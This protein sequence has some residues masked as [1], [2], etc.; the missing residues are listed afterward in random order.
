M[1]R[2]LLG[3]TLGPHRIVTVGLAATLLATTA[4]LASV[5]SASAAWNCG[6]GYCKWGY[7]YVG[8]NGLNS[9]LNS[10]TD[11]WQINYLDKN[12]GGTV[13][14][15][16]GPVDGCV[17]TKTG[18]GTWTYSIPTGCGSPPGYTHDY[19]IYISGNSSYLFTEVEYG[20]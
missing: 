16:T 19:V 11:Q 7:N 15:G 3:V 20:L 9:P 6:T 14:W 1:I 17:Y 8:P 10:P 5:G 13:Q 12:S 18:A 2:A 4:A